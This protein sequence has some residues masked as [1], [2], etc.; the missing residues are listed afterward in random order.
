MLV[1]PYA[2][3]LRVMHMYISML[4]TYH[5]HACLSSQN[6]RVIQRTLHTHTHTYTHILTYTQTNTYTQHIHRHVHI[7]IHITHIHKHSQTNTYTYTTVYTHQHTCTTHVHIHKTFTRTHTMHTH[8][9]KPPLR[10]PAYTVPR[11]PELKYPAN[12]IVSNGCSKWH[13]TSSV[14]TIQVT[15]AVPK[16]LE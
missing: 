13:I 15:I 5:I 8:T 2:A 6:A 10:A 7:T 3:E 16:Y 14:V 1:C 12:K 9:Y 4:Y 11:E